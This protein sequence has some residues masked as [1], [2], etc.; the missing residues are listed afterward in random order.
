MPFLRC[1]VTAAFCLLAAFA[2]A[3]G[4]GTFE[5]PADAEGPALRGAVWTP[6][7][8]PAGEIRLVLYSISGVPD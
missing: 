4:L 8:A 7:A 5:I 2:H 1:L 3:A 6:C